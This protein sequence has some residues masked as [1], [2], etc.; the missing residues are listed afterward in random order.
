MAKEIEQEIAELLIRNQM[1]VTTAESCTGG[2]VAGRLINA[3]GISA[4][5]RQ[6][7]ITYANEAKH[8]LL[9]VKNKTAWCSQQA[10]SK[11]DGKRRSGGCQSGCGNFRNGHC[12]T[13]RRHKRKTGRTCLYRLLCTGKGDSKGMPFF[14]QQ[15]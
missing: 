2:L 11:A 1:T 12:G 7:Y 10:D 4:A 13:G 9:G 14:R 15:K 6:G 8:K 5:Y 3:A